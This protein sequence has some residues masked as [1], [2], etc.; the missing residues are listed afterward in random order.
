MCLEHMKLI[1]YIFASNAHLSDS[2]EAILGEGRLNSLWKSR[3]GSVGKSP[4]VFLTVGLWALCDHSQLLLSWVWTYSAV[5][6][7]MQLYV[8]CMESNGK[9]A[10]FL[11]RKIKGERWDW[12]DTPVKCLGRK[13]VD[14][15]QI[16]KTHNRNYLDWR[17]SSAIPTVGGRD[18]RNV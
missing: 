5:K 15:V 3:A 18:W 10:T 2:S 4:H 14:W 13:C 6:V 8:A 1:S 7:F 11:L 12:G 17:C 16:L 9:L